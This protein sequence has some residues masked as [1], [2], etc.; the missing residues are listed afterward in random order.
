MR[1]WTKMVQNFL[2]FISV[3]TKKEF[4]SMDGCQ[5][6]LYVENSF[7]EFMNSWQKIEILFL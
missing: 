5:K 3:M 1:H 7:C 6:L 2:E 4:I